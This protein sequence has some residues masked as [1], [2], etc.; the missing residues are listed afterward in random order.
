M[1][2]TV[3]ILRP[4]FELKPWSEVAEE[5]NVTQLYWGHGKM[6]LNWHP[7]RLSQRLRFLRWQALVYSAQL[8]N[9]SVHSN[10]GSESHIITFASKKL[11]ALVYSSHRELEGNKTVGRQGKIWTTSSPLP[12]GPLSVTWVSSENVPP[13][14][15]PEELFTVFPRF[16]QWVSSWDT[17]IKSSCSHLFPLR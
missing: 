15:E 7:P 1:C 4:T 17:W 13:F 6:Y 5:L 12:R 11:F 2:P 14:T 8:C 16:F 9:H 10:A 3:I